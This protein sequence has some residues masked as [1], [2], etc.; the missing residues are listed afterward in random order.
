MPK[1]IYAIISGTMN[2]VKIGKTTRN[3]KELR[4]DFTRPY[5]S[6]MC[7]YY[8]DVNDFDLDSLERLIHN[9]LKE[10]KRTNELYEGAFYNFYIEK[11]GQIIRNFGNKDI[12]PIHAENIE[13]NMQWHPTS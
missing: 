11:I 9:E 6:N 13:G 10:Y 12:Y 4:H 1:L 5:G 8:F 3:I 7:I 2:A